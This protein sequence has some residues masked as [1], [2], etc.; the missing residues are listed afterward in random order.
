MLQ[1]GYDLS[2]VVFPSPVNGIFKAV[3][4]P[5]Q[6]A[7]D[8]ESWYAKHTSLGGLFGVF[9]EL[10]FQRRVAERCLDAGAPGASFDLA[11]C[12]R[13][14]GQADRGHDA[15]GRAVGERALGEEE[16]VAP[17]PISASSGCANT[18]M[19]RFGTSWMTWYGLFCSFVEKA[20]VMESPS[21]FSH[22]LFGFELIHDI[23]SI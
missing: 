16:A 23:Y 9:A 17:A 3:I 4:T 10:I 18:T 11:E 14:L 15:E 8:F 7:P 20:Y 19:A 13:R 22:L 6:L 1:A 5:E 2:P 21:K 12:E